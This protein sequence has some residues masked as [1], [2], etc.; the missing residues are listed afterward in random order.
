MDAITALTQRVSSGKLTEPGPDQAQCE[1][2]YKS[3]LRAADHG[4]LRPWRF[5]TVSGDDR[6]QLGELYLQAGLADD[7]ELSEA[8]Q[9]KFR[10]MPLRAP[11]VIVAIARCAEHPKVPREEMLI[12]AGAGVQN[13]INAAFALGVGA[14]WRT[15][16]MAYHPLVKQGLGIADDEEI[17]GYLYLGTPQVPPRAAPELNIGDFFSPWSTK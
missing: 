17:V 3:A 14:Y 5:L 1:A 2:I 9:S 8:R 4:C 10:A 15:G 12:S 11:L 6:H 7:P 16:A 13:M